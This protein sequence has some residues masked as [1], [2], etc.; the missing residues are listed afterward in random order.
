MVPGKTADNMCV[1][2]ASAIVRPVLRGER[3]DDVG[4]SI[5]W[6]ASVT[7]GQTVYDGD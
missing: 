6:C 7:G 1:L 5:S 4:M 2:G 3:G